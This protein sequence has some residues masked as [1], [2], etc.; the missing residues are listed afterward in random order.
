MR[1]KNDVAVP[2]KVPMMD[3]A[4]HKGAVRGQGGGTIPNT[5]S[6]VGK[7]TGAG[8]SP[9]A[10]KGRVKPDKE[11]NDSKGKGRNKKR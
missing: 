8:K 6:G 7:A 10:G 5:R 4:F 1:K 11:V 3:E 2:D 9:G